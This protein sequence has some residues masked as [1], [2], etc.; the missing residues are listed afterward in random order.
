MF[1]HSRSRLVLLCKTSVVLLY[2]HGRYST[3]DGAHGVVGNEMYI[4]YIIIMHNGLA[5]T[6]Y[7]RNLSVHKRSTV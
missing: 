3:T 1:F 7:E 2:L 5:E 6:I 4:A